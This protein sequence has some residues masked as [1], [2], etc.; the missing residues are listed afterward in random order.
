MTMDTDLLTRSLRD[1]AEEVSAPPDLALRSARGGRRRIRRSRLLGAALSVVVILIGVIVA[2]PRFGIV[3][4]EGDPRLEQPT[5]GSLAADESFLATAVQAWFDGMEFSPQASRG[6]FDDLRGEPHV[7][8][9]GATP[10]G[11]AAV[12]MQR[13]FLHKHGDLSSD[14]WNQSQTLIGLVAVDPRDGAL[15]LVSAQYRPQGDPPPGLFRFGPG[16]RTVLVVDRGLP[17]FYS[18]GPRRL[19]DGRPTRDWQALPVTDGVAIAQVPDGSDGAEAVVLARPM[20]PATNRDVAGRVMLDDAAEYLAAVDARRLGRDY[21]RHF[22]EIDKRVR[23]P[24]G[25]MSVGEPRPVDVG[26]PGKMVTALQQTDLLDIA[27]TSYI[28]LWS[29]VAG[30]S[31]GS[32]VVVSEVQEGSR[33]SR[34]YGVLY[35]ANGE[36]AGAFF[37]NDIDPIAMLPVRV[38]LP[39]GLGWIVAD[40]G[41]MLQYRTAVGGPWQPAG[42]DAALLPANAIAVEVRR[43]GV[44]PMI[45]DLTG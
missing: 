35:G 24:I 18:P 39:N 26:H 13:A 36:I 17:L 28:G 5:Q 33:P 43:S 16:S 3:D 38:R 44:T 31:D 10:S 11:R 32:T 14:D 4:W 27:G 42:V 1:A 6:L 15:K 25:A 8:W 9:A 45:V 29:V 23:W 2:T 40:R 30:L 22:P 41:S 12:V 34:A 7:Y 37:G 20:P 21:T 19:E